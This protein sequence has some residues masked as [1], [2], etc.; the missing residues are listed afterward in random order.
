MRN[1]LVLWI[2]SLFMYSCSTLYYGY[3]PG[4][5]YK[6]LKPMSEI[7]LKGMAFNIEFKDGRGSKDRISCADY[8]LDRDTELEGSRGMEYL[9]ESVVTMI[10]NS[11]GKVDSGAPNQLVVEL[12]GL[13]FK[14]IGAVYIVAHGFVE[15]RTASSYLNKVYCSDMTDHDEDAPLKWYALATRKTAT[16]EIVSGSMRRAVESFVKDLAGL[17][18]Q[19]P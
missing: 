5:E 8:T 1:T 3:L 18:P 10:K 11:N 17:S 13:S 9:R 14:L 4:T 6:I 12:N 16:R 19:Q 7:D 2:F 15:F